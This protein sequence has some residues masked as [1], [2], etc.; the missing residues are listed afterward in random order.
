MT[1]PVV[2]LGD[3][4]RVQN[5]FAFEGNCFSEVRGT[6]LIRIRDL[7][8]NR[9]SLRYDGN[10]DPSFVVQEGDLLI[11]MDGEFK[12]YRWGGPDALLNQ[13]VCRL[14]PE[15]GLL[16]I[17]YL[18]LAIGKHLHEIE[19]ATGLTT[20]KHLSSRQVADL[21]ISLP[22]F[23]DQ[24]RVAQRLTRQIAE[25]ELAREV[26]RVSLAHIEDLNEMLW[27]PKR[28]RIGTK[29]VR[30]GD[31]TRPI[32][33]G[34]TASATTSPDWPRLLRIT[35]IQDGLVNWDLVPHSNS[36]PGYSK[37]LKHGDVVV[38]RTGGFNRHDQHAAQDAVANGAGATI[39][40]VSSV[41]GARASAKGGECLSLSSPRGGCENTPRL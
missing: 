32:E 14:V 29:R 12:P 27:R 1:W 34:W 19:E 22:A 40:R 8:T 28:K 24:Q 21:E 35:D 6:P 11:G 10:Y 5:G 3:V 36:D 33:Y 4:C 37:M 15:P 25:V 20:V 17:G 23:G 7:K 18:Y 39:S 30:L 38:A 9:P 31:V 13:R 2:R 16:D 26:A 41:A